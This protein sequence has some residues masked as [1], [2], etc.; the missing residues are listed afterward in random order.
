VAA[1]KG[2]S[3]VCMDGVD[4]SEML[5]RRLSVVDVLAAKV[6]RAAETGNLFTPVRDLF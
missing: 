1:G 3:F 4:L 2:K 5:K 6:R